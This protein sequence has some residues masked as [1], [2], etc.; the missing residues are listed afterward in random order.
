MLAVGEESGRLE[1]MCLRVAHTFEGEVRRSV[2]T[3]VALIEPVMIVV[4]G[5]LVGFVALAML[6]AIYSINTSVF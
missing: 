5:V 1:D 4:F 3:A 6:Q 2:K